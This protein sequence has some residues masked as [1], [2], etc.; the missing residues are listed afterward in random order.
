MPRVN[1]VIFPAMYVGPNLKKLGLSTHTRYTDG[2]PPHVQHALDKN[3]GLRRYFIAWDEFVRSVPP[4]AVPK[5][6]PSSLPPANKKQAALARR[7]AARR[8]PLTVSVPFRT[9]L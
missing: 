2:L 9:R 6:V 3:P 8:P 1:D 7:E 4:G 5:P